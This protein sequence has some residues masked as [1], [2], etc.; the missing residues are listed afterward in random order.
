[1][2]VS[3]NYTFIIHYTT[4]TTY[5]GAAILEGNELEKFLCA[6]PF[7]ASRIEIGL[8]MSLKVPKDQAHLYHDTILYNI[9]SYN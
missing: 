2:Y 3:L 4:T 6:D 7:Y 8:K 1:M 5:S 9:L